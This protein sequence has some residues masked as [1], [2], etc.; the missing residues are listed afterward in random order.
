MNIVD[1]DL[2]GHLNDGFVAYR[3]FLAIRQHFN[4]DNKYHYNSIRLKHEHGQHSN[5]VKCSRESYEKRDNVIH[6]TKISKTFNGNLRRIEDFLIA[7]ILKNP[8]WYPPFTDECINTYKEWLRR[9]ESLHYLFETDNKHLRKRCIAEFDKMSLVELEEFAPVRLVYEYKK[10]FTDAEL[11]SV[12]FNVC[13]LSKQGMHPL[14]VREALGGRISIETLT[15]FCKM[16][17]CHENWDYN[18]PSI[19]AGVSRCLSYESLLEWDLDKCTRI[20]RSVW[21]P[22][23]NQ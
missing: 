11:N 3:M 10:A 22:T 7:N 8:K 19:S 12:Y 4:P 5:L 6:F 16:S 15:V 23:K 9:V 13:V 17:G 14:I 21:H 1:H 18:D 20:M 2:Q